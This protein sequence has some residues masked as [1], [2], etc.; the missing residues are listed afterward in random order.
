MYPYLFQ[1][2]EKT[3]DALT[4]E[5]ATLEKQNYHANVGNFLKDDLI[6]EMRKELKEATLEVQNQCK[7]FNI[8]SLFFLRL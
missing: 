4:T 3:Q 8:N 2:A 5:I 7:I 6:K 1:E